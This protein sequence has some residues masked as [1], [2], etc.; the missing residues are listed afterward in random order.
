MIEVHMVNLHVVVMRLIDKHIHGLSNN[1][2]IFFGL[3]LCFM[4]EFLLCSR[5][6]GFVDARAIG[7][8]NQV[9]DGDNPTFLILARTFLG[10]D[11]VFLGG[12]SQQFLGTPLTL[13][14]WLTEILDMIATSIVAKYGP[15]NFPSKAVL[16]TK[17]Q[18]ESHWVKFLDKKSNISI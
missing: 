2:Q 7:I 4:G 18:I 10:L 15:S 9:G 3:A 5:R 11:S 12:E 8:V 13:Q 6:P 16:K 14:I 1:M 17:C